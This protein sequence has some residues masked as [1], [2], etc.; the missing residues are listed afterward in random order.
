MMSRALVGLLPMTRQNT[1]PGIRSQKSTPDVDGHKTSSRRVEFKGV[2]DRDARGGKPR[3]WATMTHRECDCD[4][5]DIDVSYR[6]CYISVNN[7]AF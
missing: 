3:Q 7:N 2:R 6:M 4:D 5:A 1:R